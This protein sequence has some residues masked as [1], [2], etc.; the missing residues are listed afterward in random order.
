LVATLYRPAERHLGVRT[1]LTIS[2]TVVIVWNGV[3]AAE[4]SHVAKKR[5]PT[6][7]TWTKLPHVNKESFYGRDGMS[8]FQFFR[9]IR[10]AAPR[11]CRYG[12]AFGEVNEG[13]WNPDLSGSLFSELRA[14]VFLVGD[15]KSVGT[16]RYYQ[17][18]VV[19][20]AEAEKL[21]AEKCTWLSRDA[22]RLL[23]WR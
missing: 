20:P 3:R 23:G 9:G 15:P 17:P 18:P 22:S 16:S 12:F 13:W 5:H 4:Y 10:E 19:T 8:W 14:P 6:L 11:A 2:L 7:D 1:L 21:A